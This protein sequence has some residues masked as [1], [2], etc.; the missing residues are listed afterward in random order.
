[1][2]NIME[3]IKK[4]ALVTGA[5]AGI[6]KAT[7]LRLKEAGYIVCCAARRI[8]TMKEL[9]NKGIHILKL[10]V[11]NNESIESCI[12]EII[13][14]YGRLD[15]LVNNAG[16]GSYGALEDVPL[17]EARYQFEVNI[18]GLARLTQLALPFMR[19]HNFG[20]IVNVSSIGGKVWE[21]ISCWYKASKFA[22]E[23]LSDCLRI[24]VKEFGIDEDNMFVFWDWVGGRYSLWSAIG[25]SIVCYI[26]F[27]NFEELL[28]G[29]FEMDRHFKNTSFEKNIL[30]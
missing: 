22:L 6:G 25:L 15:I 19:K 29:A 18:F 11:S 14:K 3:I 2:E 9:E 13:T 1:M 28:Q 7:A 24:E 21:P 27:D 16:Y 17:K 8:E 12:N 20:K 4:V 23:G 5:S 26:G 10:D 30:L